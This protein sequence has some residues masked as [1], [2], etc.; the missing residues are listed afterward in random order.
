VL[1]VD[2]TARETV[3]AMRRAL[4][5]EAEALRTDIDQARALVN[6]YRCRVCL[7]PSVRS[8]GT[9]RFI[10]CSPACSRLWSRVRYHLDADLRARHQRTIARWTLANADTVSSGRCRSAERVLADTVVKRGRWTVMG[11][12][13]EQALAQVSVLRGA[14]C[15]R[16]GG[17]PASERE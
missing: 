1:A 13:V 7:G 3:A 15:K 2:P 12:S 16:W 6:G 14:V 5:I 10:T 11:S 9:K 8:L 17:P 4:R